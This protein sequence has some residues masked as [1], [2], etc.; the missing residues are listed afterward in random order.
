MKTGAPLYVR[1][2][3]IALDALAALPVE[4]PYFFW[5]G[6]SKL[7][8]A[9][10]S[11]RRTNDNVFIIHYWSW[12]AAISLGPDVRVE[13]SRR[14]DGLA[15]NTSPN[16]IRSMSESLTIRPE[17]PDRFQTGAF[18]PR[19]LDGR[20]VTDRHHR[21]VPTTSL[22]QRIYRDVWQTQAGFS[23]PINSARPRYVLWP[24]LT[25]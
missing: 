21:A 3:Q 23:G 12:Q 4:S 16:A 20:A 25:N 22:F 5:S 7:S 19:L 11:A 17:Q 15:G 14:V 9:I 6:K 8:C 13:A 10:G 1:L 18:L 24:V 2:P